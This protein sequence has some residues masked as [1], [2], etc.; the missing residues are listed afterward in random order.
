MFGIRKKTG[1]SP[2]YL[3]LSLVFMLTIFGLVMLTS[4]SSALGKI[5]FNDNYY[6]IKHQIING[7]LVG[8]IGFFIGFKINYQ[9]IKK[10]SFPILIVSLV[11]ISL[12]FTKFGVESGGARR[13]V[14]IGPVT[15][16][17]AEF[18][19]I[20]FIAYL[21]AWLSNPRFE[22][23]KTLYQ[24]FVPFILISGLAACLLF[25]QP[26]TSM[27]VIL[28]GAGLI[29]YFLSGAK[30][31]YLATIILGGIAVLALLISTTPYRLERVRGFIGANENPNSLGY[32]LNESLIAIGSG[33]FGGLG[34]GESK[35]KTSYLPAPIDDSIFAVIAEELG[36]IGASMLLA[37]FAVL[38][39][40][41]F[42]ISKDSRDS[43]AK[44]A[45]AGFAS[46]IGIQ[47][48]IN[49]GAISGL[50]PITGI[51]LPF[52]SYGGTALAAFLT[53]SGLVANVS[54]Y[55]KN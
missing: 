3:F 35:T 40:R 33:G 6:Y 42:W 15:F 8:I 30:L 10:F 22:R 31:R 36:F 4:A 41:M 55:T 2:D 20:A 11:L 50:M 48:I 19:K 1:H 21:A 13:W 44:L 49:I 26:A 9:Y 7:F 38:V 45:V 5:K 34:L 24:G 29:V 51:P 23:A 17:P 14:S 47:S 37:V 54:K 18:L 16:Q 12:V 28:M 32:H 39:F 53:M 46:I 52:I 43:F 27:V 25:L